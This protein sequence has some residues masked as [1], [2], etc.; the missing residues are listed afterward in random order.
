MCTEGDL[1]S[2]QSQAGKFLTTPGSKND[3]ASSAKISLEDSASIIE[4]N[5]WHLIDPNSM[6]SVPFISQTTKYSSRHENIDLISS[7]SERALR[8]SR[9]SI[10]S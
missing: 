9:D 4:S 7:S 3:C 2:P 1:Y 8:L 6:R 10:T 5:D